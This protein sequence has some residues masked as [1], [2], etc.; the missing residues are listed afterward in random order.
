M[1]LG[2]RFELLALEAFLAT[3]LTLFVL[4][5]WLKQ[6]YQLDFSAAQ[7]PPIHMPIAFGR[8]DLAKAK[9]DATSSLSQPSISRGGGNVEGSAGPCSS[10]DPVRTVLQGNCHFCIEHSDNVSLRRGWEVRG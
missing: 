2:L 3:G 1:G 4:V 7:Q 6:E 9:P 5:R 8:V 10:K